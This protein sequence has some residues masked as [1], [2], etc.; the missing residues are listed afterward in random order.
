MS[1]GEAE[2]AMVKTRLTQI[3]GRFPTYDWFVI[4]WVLA[5]KVFAVRGWWAF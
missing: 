3:V 5:I 4:G 2:I 1:E